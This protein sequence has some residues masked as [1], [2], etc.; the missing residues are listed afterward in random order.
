MSRLAIVLPLVLGAVSLCGC[1]RRSIENLPVPEQ[2]T[3]Y[4]LLGFGEAR[5]EMESFHR[6]PVLGKIEVTDPEQRRE[7][8]MALHKGIDPSVDITLCFQ[9]RH[10]IRA[11]VDG[12]TTDYVIC[13]ECYQ[14]RI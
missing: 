4:S 11:V 12:Q 13:Y 6:Y 1:S 7:I 3:L 5:G 2:L 9:P 14:V 10:G 8:Y